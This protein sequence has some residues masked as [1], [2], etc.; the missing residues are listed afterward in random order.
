MAKD[1]VPSIYT[2]TVGVQT[3]SLQFPVGELEYLRT[4]AAQQNTS[5]KEVIRRALAEMFPSYKEIYLSHTPTVEDLEGDY[6][7]IIIGS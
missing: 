1:K 7:E 2:N 3:T 4:L 6:Q 5:M